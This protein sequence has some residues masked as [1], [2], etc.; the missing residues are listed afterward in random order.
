MN[1]RKVNKHLLKQYITRKLNGLEWLAIESRLS[2]LTIN[3]IVASGRVP[4][5]RTMTILSECT[6]IHIDTLFPLVEDE[7]DQLAS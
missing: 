2:S 4:S 1:K 6:G 5:L 3:H 7:S